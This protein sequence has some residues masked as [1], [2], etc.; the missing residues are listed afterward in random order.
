MGDRPGMGLRAVG[1]FSPAREALPRSRS[2][3]A[4]P[5]AAPA[6]SREAAVGRAEPG[7]GQQRLAPCQRLADRARLPPDRRRPEH[8]RGD[9]GLG[10][11]RQ[12]ELQPRVRARER[13]EPERPGVEPGR[14][15]G[16]TLTRERSTGP[17]EAA[18]G[19]AP[20]GRLPGVR[21]P[22]PSG[23]GHRAAP[24]PSRARRRIAPEAPRL[25]PVRA[26]AGPRPRGRAPRSRPSRRPRPDPWARPS[27]R[28]R[29][30]H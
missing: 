5:G 24:D 8:H 26:A 3:A 2:D 9:A 15:R 17:A 16:R 19:P 14:K 29:K 6:P 27:F 10:L 23:G 28:R 11:Q 7:D 20:G 4:T 13:P 1:C 25:T 21:A 22:V 12:V 30:A 18:F